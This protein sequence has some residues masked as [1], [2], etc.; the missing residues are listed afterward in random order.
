MIIKVKKVQ[1]VNKLWFWLLKSNVTLVRLYD[2]LALCHGRGYIRICLKNLLRSI[3]KIFPR[4]F[5]FS[6]FQVGSA[7][8]ADPGP[9]PFT[10]RACRQ[11]HTEI[12]KRQNIQDHHYFESDYARDSADDIDILSMK[13]GFLWEFLWLNSMQS[14]CSLIWRENHI[15]LEVT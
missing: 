5:Q 9:S 8:W 10:I 11:V 2:S 14:W 3:C 4:F 6:S 12:W 7:N 13:I 15:S 1:K